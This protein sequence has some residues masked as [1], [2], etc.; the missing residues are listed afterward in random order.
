MLTSCNR[1]QGIQFVGCC[2]QLPS[3]PFPLSSSPSLFLTY[4]SNDKSSLEFFRRLF[5]TAADAAAFASLPSAA[6]ANCFPLFPSLTCVGTC[7]GCIRKFR[8]NFMIMAARILIDTLALLTG[9]MAPEACPE[10]GFEFRISISCRIHR[11]KMMMLF[12]MMMIS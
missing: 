6:L 7:S 8:C 11:I 4:T 10:E 5:R 2:R 12:L 9:P 3:L 1:P